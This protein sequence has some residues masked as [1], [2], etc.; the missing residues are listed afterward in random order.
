MIAGEVQNARC[1]WLV[2]TKKSK[3][4]KGVVAVLNTNNQLNSAT[5]YRCTGCVMAI[6]AC[7]Y[8]S[9]ESMAR[10]RLRE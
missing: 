10:F 3:Q 6:T 7:P 2:E 8:P 5:F 4:Q 9:T 1:R